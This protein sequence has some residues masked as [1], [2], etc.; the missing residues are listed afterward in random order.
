MMCNIELPIPRA[1]VLILDLLV[2]RGRSMSAG[3]ICR[4]GAL[5]GVSETTMRVTLARLE[6][7]GRIRRVRRGLYEVAGTVH[8]L[9]RVIRHWQRKRAMVIQWKAGE[10][11][12]IY[13]GAVQRADRTAYRHHSLALSLFGF[14]ELR[15]GLYVRP[16]NLAGGIPRMLRRLRALGLAEQAIGFKLSQLEKHIDVEARRLWDVEA[17]SS[18]DL[19][20]LVALRASAERLGRLSLEAAAQESLLLGRLAIA[21]LVRDPVLPAELMT[22]KTRDQL[23]AE[24]IAYQSRAREL[25]Q[26]WL[27]RQAN[28]PASKHHSD[29]I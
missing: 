14:A 3:E 18:A 12:A 22:T 23:L 13:D 24:A 26:K 27:G 2:G 4:A 19:K 25:W 5:L 6:K 10:W 11:A 8:P 28:Q 15:P 1:P 29:G 7:R 17:L 20:Y 16:N 9:H 21:H